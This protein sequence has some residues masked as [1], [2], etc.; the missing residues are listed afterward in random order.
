[1]V[2]LILFSY[3]HFIFNRSCLIISEYVAEIRKKDRK[4]CWPFGSLGDPEKYDVFASYQS[5][6]S[7]FL[8]SP[9][10]HIDGSHDKPEH[11]EASNCKS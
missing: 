11:K 4:K 8:C 7:T 2:N 1:M 6:D 10:D 3:M 5:V 9:S